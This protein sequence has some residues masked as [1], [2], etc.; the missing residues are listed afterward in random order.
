MRGDYQRD[1]R[2]AE[3]SHIKMSWQ[4]YIHMQWPCVRA[5]YLHNANINKYN[6][7]IHAYNTDLRVSFFH[8]THA[9]VALQLI[10]VSTASLKLEPKASNDLFFPHVWSCTTFCQF[11]A[12]SLIH[13]FLKLESNYFQK[14]T[15][16]QL[17]CY[18]GASNNSQKGSETESCLFAPSFSNSIF[19]VFHIPVFLLWFFFSVNC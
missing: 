19:F 10:G 11:I 15:L 1:P 17:V 9:L 14:H 8:L 6:R 16:P 13:R 2:T 7:Y 18:Q 4:N 3:M 12:F 5:L